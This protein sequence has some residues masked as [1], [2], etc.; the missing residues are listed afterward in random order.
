MNFPLLKRLSEAAG[1]PGQE[2]QLRDIVREE[3]AQ[4]CSFQV[5]AMGNLICTKPATHNSGGVTKRVMIAAHMDEIGFVVKHIDDKGFLRVHTLGGWDPRQMPAQRVQVHTETAVLSGNMMLTTKPKHMLS[6]DEANKPPKVDDFIIDL[7]LDGEQVK[8]LVS[9]G[10]MVVMDRDCREM[11]NLISGKAM[12]NRVAVYVMIEA[13]KALADHGAEIVGVATTQEEIGLRGAIAA[14][15]GLAPDIC[16]AIDVTLANDIPGIPEQDHVTKLGA[17]TA[18][19]I[20]DSSLICHPLVV[21]H[22]KSLAIQHGIDYQM[23]L[24]PFGGTDAA[25]V[26]KQHGGVPSFTLSVPCRYVHTVNETV[27][28]SDLDASV[29]LLRRYLEDAHNGDYTLQ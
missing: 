15:S 29:E 8:S 3:L 21:K 5:D 26:Q 10:D 24:L 1:V 23:E 13:M 25:G 16:I 17:G 6:G 22:F 18:I 14:G 28:P 11:G 27:H 4:I 12:D 9:I 7:G 19:K 2:Q 20:M